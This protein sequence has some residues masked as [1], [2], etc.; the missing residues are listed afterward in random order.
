MFKTIVSEILPPIIYKTL[1]RVVHGNKNHYHPAWH[2][3]EGGDLKGRQIFVDPKGGTWQREMI[4]GRYDRFI[5][6]YAHSLDLKGK[7][8]FEIGA[9]IGFHAMNFAYLVGVEGFVYAFE[10]NTFNRERMGMILDK[11]PDLSERIKIFDVAISDT[12]GQEV[13]YFCKDVERGTSSGSFI[14]RAHTYYPK[15]KEYLEQF[16]ITTV[17]TVSLDQIASLIGADIIPHV[18]KVDVEGAESSVLKGAVEM[19][20]RHRTLV[21]MEIHSIYNMLRVYEILQSVGYTIELL[22]EE[23]D[24]RCFIAAQPPSGAS[25]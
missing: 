11:N 14:S 13:F 21:L 25:S 18:M 3:V 20:K 10:P 23:S 15:S 9:H 19:L 22:K 4:E 1:S 8:V 2:T 12:T 5:F 16:E 6:E 24:G 17:K 7:I